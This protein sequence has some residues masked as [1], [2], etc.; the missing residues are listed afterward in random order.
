MQ[1][2]IKGLTDVDDK[3]NAPTLVAA[4]RFETTCKK[5]RIL[6]QKSC[7]KA[8]NLSSLWN[9]W[10]FLLCCPFIRCR[11]SRLAI[12]VSLG[13]H[14]LFRQLL[15]PLRISTPSSAS[16]VEDSRPQVQLLFWTCSA[17]HLAIRHQKS[18]TFQI[19]WWDYVGI[20]DHQLP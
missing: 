19:E 7:I 17:V 2:I 1:L 3:Q 8:L 12:C 13:L 6:I 15:L 11:S 16:Q 4:D 5:S 20:R 10:A 14:R 9:I 18:S